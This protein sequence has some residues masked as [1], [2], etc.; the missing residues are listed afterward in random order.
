MI[1]LFQ[2][3]FVLFAVYAIFFVIKKKQ[4]ELLGPKGMLFWIVF[5]IAVIVVVVWPNSAAMIAHVFG[6]GRGADFVMYMA[7]AILFFIVFR[8][9]IKI[10]IMNRDVTKVVR[11]K[12]LTKHKNMKS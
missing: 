8:L 10:E 4:D 9:H 5:W 12:A 3:L 11:E 7:L 1:I 2:M 6:I